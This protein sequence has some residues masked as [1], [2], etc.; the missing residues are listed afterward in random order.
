MP[1]C[2]SRCQQIDL[3]R[4]FSEDI[5]LPIEP[6]DEFDEQPASDN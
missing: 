4:W 2:S 5:G 3:G 6:E 1:F